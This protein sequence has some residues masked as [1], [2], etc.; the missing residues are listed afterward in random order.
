VPEQVEGIAI[1]LA[2]VAGFE[3]GT[4]VDVQ[5]GGAGAAKELA[6]GEKASAAC[7]DQRS[8]MDG[9]RAGVGVS[10]GEFKAAV[11]DLGP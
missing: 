7:E 9:D 6:G 1:G 11:A 2:P 8:I 4:L 3:S 5:V 10:V